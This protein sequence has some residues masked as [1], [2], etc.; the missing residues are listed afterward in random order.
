VT[1]PIAI[2]MVGRSLTAPASVS[3][4]HSETLVARPA[5]KS[6]MISSRLPEVASAGGRSSI[7]PAIGCTRQPLGSVCDSSTMSLR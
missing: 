3:K 4:S 1:R 5:R 7:A 6:R 2:I